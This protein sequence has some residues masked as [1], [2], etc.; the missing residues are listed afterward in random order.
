M[1]IHSYAH[2]TSHDGV[3]FV[4]RGTQMLA[5]GGGKVCEEMNTGSGSVWASRT[6]GYVINYS[7][8]STLCFMTSRHSPAGPWTPVGSADRAG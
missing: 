1:V 6:G 7:H 2:A 8:G 4:D 5:F 3:H